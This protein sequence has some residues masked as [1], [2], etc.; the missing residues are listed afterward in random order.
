MLTEDGSIYHYLSK[1]LACHLQHF[2]I[3][4]GLM[5]TDEK[6]KIRINK[7]GYRTTTQ[8]T[9]R[10]NTVKP[11]RGLYRKMWLPPTTIH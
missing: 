11:G 9:A 5:M 7:K 1:L 3:Y 8:S 2:V 10:N 4:V 6:W